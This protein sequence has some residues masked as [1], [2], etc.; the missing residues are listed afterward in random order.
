MAII[1]LKQL[2]GGRQLTVKYILAYR[3]LAT[4]IKGLIDIRASGYLFIN[5]KV[6]KILK[7]QFN[8]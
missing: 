2:I 8:A 6:A 3:G 7:R 4:L 5:K 1:N